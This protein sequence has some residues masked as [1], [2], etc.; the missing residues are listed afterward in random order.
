MDPR[1]RARRIALV[2]AALIVAAS[3]WPFGGWRAPAG[4]EAAWFGLPWPRGLGWFDVASNVV[5]Y[6][7]LGAS[8]AAALAGPGASPAHRLRAALLGLLAASALSHAM[9]NLQRWM[10]GRTPSVI[11]WLLNGLGAGLGVAAWLAA[12]SLRA[13]REPSHGVDRP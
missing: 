13:R 1:R 12:G 9:E 5:A 8:T 4:F 7:P 10:L 2:C 11:D 3:L 6:L